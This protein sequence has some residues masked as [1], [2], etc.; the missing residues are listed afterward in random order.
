VPHDFRVFVA[1]DP[2]TT[3]G[4]APLADAPDTTELPR[5]I[6]LAP[7]RAA[8]GEAVAPLL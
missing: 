2:E 6:R 4:C 1:T 7:D 8:T 3:V 5:L